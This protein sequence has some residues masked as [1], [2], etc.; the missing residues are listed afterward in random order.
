LASGFQRKLK[1]SPLAFLDLCRNHSI[2]TEDE[3]WALAWD[4]EAKG[5]KA[6]M[7]Y[8]ME[9]DVEAALVKVGKAMGARETLARASM[10]RMDILKAYAAERQCTCPTQ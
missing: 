5:D 7:A 4:L 1:L 9:N 8:A 6:L 3:L 2:Q 10:T